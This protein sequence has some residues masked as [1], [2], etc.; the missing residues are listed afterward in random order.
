[1]C[2][3]DILLHMLLDAV[4]VTQL[5]ETEYVPVSQKRTS[6]IVAYDIDIV[7]VLK[8]GYE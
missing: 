1:M 2:E 5:T 6:H 7:S 4:P 3:C 8:F